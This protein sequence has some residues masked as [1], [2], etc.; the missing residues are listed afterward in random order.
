MG[1]LENL[2]QVF[3][4]LPSGSPVE[5]EIGFGKGLHL[6]NA[7][8]SNP[9]TRYL[10]I[11]IER[12]YVL[13][14]ATTLVKNGIRNVRLVTGDAT[15]FVA[16]HVPKAILDV[17]HI[18]FPDPWWKKRHHKRRLVTLAFLNQVLD[19]LKPGGLIRFATDVEAYFQ[20]TEELLPELKGVSRST[21]VSADT[22][23]HDMD[24][25]TH[26]ERK[27]CLKG[28]PIFRWDLKKMV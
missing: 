27:A 8:Q 24:Y 11:E 19:L 28:K 10:G 20:M 6:V 9:Q 25:L 1:P 12:K 21:P 2:A 13:F 17:V 18:Y 5:L 26:F 16:N 3:P 23:N 14:A 7:S 4:D 15:I 22:P